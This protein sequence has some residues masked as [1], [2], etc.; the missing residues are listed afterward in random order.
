MARRRISLF[1]SAHLLP[2]VLLASLLTGNTAVHG[3]WNSGHAH[4]TAGAVNNL[5]QPLRTFVEQNISIVTALSGNEP[6]G[7]HWIDVDLYPEF[8][9]G[10]LPRDRAELEAL[11]SPSIV[12]ARGTGPWTYVEYV[13]TLTD[14]MS[15]ASSAQD[16]LSLL[17]IAAAQAHYA[18]DLHNPLH[19]TFNYNGQ[20]TGNSG[21]HARYE[22]QMISRQFDDL[23][24]DQVEATYE[25]SVLDATFDRIEINYYF[26]DDILAAD[27]LYAGMPGGYDDAYYDGLWAETGEFTRG[28]FQSASEAVANGWYTAWVDA[29]SPVPFIDGDFN[30]DGELDVVDLDALVAVTAAM[31]NDLSFDLTSDGNVNEADLH[32][33]LVLGGAANSASGNPYLQGDAN[34]DGTVDG[35]DFLAWNSSK[36]TN[37]A[38]WTAG[39]FN[40]DGVVDGG[41]FLTWNSNKFTSADGHDGYASVPEPSSMLLVLLGAA[42]TARRRRRF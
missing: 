40:G 18:Q 37:T 23:T 22:G 42:W 17:S 10:T 28:L 11:Y 29:G 33:W 9:E 2:V 1:F 5:P 30:S 34:L 20:F 32:A 15:S 7:T 8:F 4:I 39:D 16:W 19:L 12:A 35:Q 25:A 6:P 31:S 24:F 14:A 27:D 41:D 3:W 26:V 21:I 13:E 36:F 38:A